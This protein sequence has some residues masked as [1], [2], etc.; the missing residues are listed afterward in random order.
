MKKI[1]FICAN[2]LYQFLEDIVEKFA[3]DKA[4]YVVRNFV[5]K[6]EQEIIEAIEWG[7]ILWFEWANEIAGIGTKYIAKKGLFAKKVIIRMHG[8]EALRADL[9]QKIEWLAVNKLIVV[10]QHVLE[11]AIKNDPRIGKLRDDST[12]LL[13]TSPSPRD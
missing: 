10:A 12:C 8:Y 11:E 6:N 1:S 13:Y 9:L 5:V 4:N 2:G 7:D 3:E